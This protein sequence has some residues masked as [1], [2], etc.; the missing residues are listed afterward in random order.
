MEATTTKNCRASHRGLGLLAALCF[1]VQQFLLPLH[2]ALDEHSYL[3]TR[4]D[5]LVSAGEHG[6]AHGHHEHGVE[7]AE[8]EHEPHPAE[9]HLEE[10]PDPVLRPSVSK[11]VLAASSARS[12]IEVAPLVPRGE[13]YATTSGPRAPPERFATPPRAPP[14]AI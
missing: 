11:T 14:I 12:V 9:E 4:A 10:A 13:V 5:R 2:L 8:A 3:E 1:V 6:H 7:A